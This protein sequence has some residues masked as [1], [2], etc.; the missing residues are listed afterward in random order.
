VFVFNLR[1][2]LEAVREQDATL[3]DANDPREVRSKVI[4]AHTDRCDNFAHRYF[5]VEATGNLFLLQS[6]IE[7]MAI[8]SYSYP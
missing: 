4:A 5:A 8:W 6:G 7:L 3:A 2:C 1:T